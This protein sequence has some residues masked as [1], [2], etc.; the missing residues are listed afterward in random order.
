MIFAGIEYLI[1]NWILYIMLVPFMI[2]GFLLKDV[3][4]DWQ[5]S[6]RLRIKNGEPPSP[7]DRI[8]R[9]R[10]A[11]VMFLIVLALWYLAGVIIDGG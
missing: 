1:S 2:A 10:H 9:W 6:K 7:A 8:F 3:Y 11:P 4:D 5:M